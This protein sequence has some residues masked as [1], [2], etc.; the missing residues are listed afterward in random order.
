MSNEHERLKRFAPYWEGRTMNELFPPWV[1]VRF[2]PSRIVPQHCLV[3]RT[4]MSAEHIWPDR[5]TPRC[6]CNSCY[7]QEIVHKINELCIITGQPLPPEKIQ[8]QKRWARHVPDN[9]LDGAPRDYYTFI[10]NVIYGS[11]QA[12]GE[13]RPDPQAQNVLPPQVQGTLPPPQPQ[14]TVDD[15]FNYSQRQPEYVPISNSSSGEASFGHATGSDDYMR[16]VRA[17]YEANHFP[18]EDFESWKE[19]RSKKVMRDFIAC[20]QRD[21]EKERD[22]MRRVQDGPT[23]CGELRDGNGNFVHMDCLIDGVMY[24]KYPDGRI[25]KVN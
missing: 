9:I 21:S 24:R 10:A 3:C 20:G 18:D 17:M 12:T 7:N 15:M 25:E 11:L 4:E 5:L 1:M 6:M 23:L 2:P 16:Q 22:R 14:M 13:V 19:R 8:A